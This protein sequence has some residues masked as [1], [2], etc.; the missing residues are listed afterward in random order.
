MEHLPEGWTQVSK[1]GVDILTQKFIF[2]DFQEAMSFALR[3]GEAADEADH[4]P[5]IVVNWGWVQV[6]WWSHDAQGVTARDISLAQKT[7][8]LYST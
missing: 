3:I 8:Q 7:S 2:N 1:N 4:H 6:D 5:Q